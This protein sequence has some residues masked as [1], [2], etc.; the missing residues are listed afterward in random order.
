VQVSP[1]LPT[2]VLVRGRVVVHA[3]PKDRLAALG[4]STTSLVIGKEVVLVRGARGIK[5]GDVLTIAD[6]VHR[7]YH[8]VTGVSDPRVAFDRAVG[9]LRFDSASISPQSAPT[10]R[11]G[12]AAPPARSLS[13]SPATG[14]GSPTRSSPTRARS[15]PLRSRC[16]TWSAQLIT[17]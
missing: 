8:Q 11:S 3:K 1:D 2:G 5:I 14:S 17:R 13:Q 6:Q 16:A 9:E 12:A 7:S 10:P 15:P 4:P